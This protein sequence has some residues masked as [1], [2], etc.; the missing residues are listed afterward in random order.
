MHSRS[1]FEYHRNKELNSNTFFGERAGLDK[2]PFVQN[3]FGGVLG[4]PVLRNK[5]FFFSSYEGYRNR[6]G[7]L[8]R[9]TVPTA[10]DEARRLSPII[11]TWLQVPSC[12]STTMDT[13]GIV[14]P[15]TG[16]TTGT[17]GRCPIGCSSPATS[18][19]LT[20]SARSHESIWI[21]QSSPNLQCR[22]HGGPRTLNENAPV[23]AITISSVSR[24][25][26]LSQK[27]RVLGRYTRFE[28]TNLP[29]TST[30]NGQRQR[31]PL[32]AGATSSRPR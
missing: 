10:G 7:V 29:S 18:F 22:A 25:Y 3:N 8:F 2:P 1:V 30:A 16:V 21:S 17:V 12:Q 20:A 24:D 9:R 31:G 15:G 11:G 27:Q 23:V 32:L 4:G 6:E 13:C 19:R 28:S 26:N 5:L 14:N